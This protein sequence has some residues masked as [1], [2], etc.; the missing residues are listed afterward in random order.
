MPLPPLPQPS[1]V[2]L[3]VLALGALI[4]TIT[5][6]RTRRIPNVLTASL[7]GIGI[8]M[9]ATDISGIGAGAA[10]GGCIIGLMLMMP[11]YLLGA[12]GAGDVKLMAAVGAV[13]GPALVVTAFLFTAV[14]GGVLALVVATQR[15]RVGA[16]L[17]GTGR[18]I[19]TPTGARQQLQ[20]APATRRF[21]YGPAIAIGS[22]LAAFLG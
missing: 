10:L 17:A 3:V 19:A 9:G 21:A 8:A 13:L 7:S 1:N 6:I 11:G 15:G 16:T 4:A 22:V 18:L 12:T 2:A 20:E 14:A 5:D